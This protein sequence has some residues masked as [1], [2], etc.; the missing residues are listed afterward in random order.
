[1][2]SMLPTSDYRPSEIIIIKL[3]AS[4]TFIMFTVLIEHLDVKN[5]IVNFS[6]SGRPFIT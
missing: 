6:S 4:K 2:T 3:H 1:M 5:K